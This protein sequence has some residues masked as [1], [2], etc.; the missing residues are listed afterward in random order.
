MSPSCIAG[1]AGLGSSGGGRLG[2]CCPSLGCVCSAGAVGA[3]GICGVSCF[4]W[5]CLSVSDCVVL[6]WDGSGCTGGSCD[7]L[8][9]S[10]V[11]SF[12]G[13]GGGYSDI[14]SFRLR[15]S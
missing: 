4:I 2:D 9:D 3:V 8:I 1:S 13:E 5:L 10:S 11:S 12:R 14:Q 7:S 6:G 15:T